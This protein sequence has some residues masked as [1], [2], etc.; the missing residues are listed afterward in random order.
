MSNLLEEI[1]LTGAHSVICEA[2]Y[3]YTLKH[4]AVKLYHLAVD[5]IMFFFREVMVVCWNLL[6]PRLD[7]VEKM[8]KCA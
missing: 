3:L 1:G 4:Q 6:L 8:R 5:W 2:N 7:M